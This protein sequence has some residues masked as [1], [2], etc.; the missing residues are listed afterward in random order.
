MSS[1]LRLLRFSLALAAILAILI[2]LPA[3]L[4]GAIGQWQISCL[5]LSYFCFFLSTVWRTL[6]YEL[7]QRSEDEQVKSAS[8]RLAFAVQLV[9]I[10]GVHWLAIYEFSRTDNLNPAIHTFSSILSLVLICS[11]IVINWAAVYHLGKFFDRLTIKPDHQLIETGIYRQIRHPIY[12][13]YLLL[14]TGYCLMIGSIWSLILLALVCFVW[15]GN[16][17]KIEEDMLENKFG[18]EYKAYKQKTKKLLPF[19]Y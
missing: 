11:S 16:R 8:G 18:E 15:F 7:A 3:I 6:K 2:A 14:F 1:F 9:G 12:L 19:V 5:L 4:F 13:S 10:V 17:I